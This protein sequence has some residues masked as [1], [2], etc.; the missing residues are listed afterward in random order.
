M[1]YS[2]K[3]RA[4]IW[5]DS[6]PLSYGEKRKLLKES[7]DGVKLVNSLSQHAQFF[8][9]EEKKVIF[10]KM[11]ASLKDN[12]KYYAEY[13][14]GLDEKGIIPI[15]LGN[16]FY[17]K[18][19]EA[20][21]DKPLVFYAKGNIKLLKE[22]KFAV[23]GSRRISPA[24]AKLGESISA[25]VSGQFTLLTG[26][27]DGGDSAAIEGGLKGSGKV[28]CLLAGGFSSLPQT[29]LTARVAKSGLLLS[30]HSFDT[31]T[32]SFSFEYRNKLLACL[33]E[34]VL[35]LS[36]GERSGAL[37]TARYAEE[38]KKPIFAIPYPPQAAFGSGCNAL[39]KKGGVLTENSFDIL[40]RFGLN[41]IRKTPAVSLTAEEEKVLEALREV[42]ESHAM[43]IA[44]KAGV[45]PYKIAAVLSSL[46]VKG[47]VVRVGGNSFAPVS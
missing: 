25:D 41:L 37:I 1:Q 8:V 34:G 16:E 46:E 45:P 20:L 36:A 4:Y 11:L 21:T 39:I 32:M 28:V 38:F 17:P 13:V 7:G 33:A 22:R 30:P 23:V 29:S 9:E 47:L 42:P 14:K 10:Q 26:V 31:P 19:V 6:F 35:V 18:E 3:E 5:L 2:S 40:S 43:D 12:G 44:A 15:P 24:I 27:A